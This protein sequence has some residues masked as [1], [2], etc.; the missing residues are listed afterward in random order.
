MNFKRCCRCGCFYITNGSVC[1]NC[2]QKEEADLFTLKNF[3]YENGIPNS[4]IQ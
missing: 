1:P 3:C 2:I 4:I